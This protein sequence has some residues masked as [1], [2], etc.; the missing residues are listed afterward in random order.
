MRRMEARTAAGG[1]AR[2]GWPCWGRWVGI[3]GP[4]FDA[5]YNVTFAMV[6]YQR[7][8]AGDFMTINRA[9]RRSAFR[10]I[11]FRNSGPTQFVLQFPGMRFSP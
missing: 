8:E 4:V 9:M 11:G 5:C 6:E 10:Q 3:A 1:W 7:A 2:P